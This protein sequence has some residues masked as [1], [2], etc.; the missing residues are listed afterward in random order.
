MRCEL[1]PTDIDLD[2]EWRPWTAEEKV[3]FVAP[4]LEDVAESIAVARADALAAYPDPLAPIDDRP[5]FEPGRTPSSYARQVFVHRYNPTTQRFHTPGGSASDPYAFEWDDA[6]R[7][8]LDWWISSEPGHSV[9]ADPGSPPWGKVANLIERMHPGDLV[10]MDRTGTKARRHPQNPGLSVPPRS[11][12]GVTAVEALTRW[13]DM[14]WGNWLGDVHMTPL[15]LFDVPVHLDSVRKRQPAMAAIGNFRG[16]SPFFELSERDDVLAIVQACGLPYTVLT[17]PDLDALARLLQTRPSGDLGAPWKELRPGRWRALQNTE[18]EWH[19]M[20]A[21]TWWL[22]QHGF[23]HVYVHRERGRGYDIAARRWVGQHRTDWHVEVK[24]SER[25]WPAP[26]SLTPNQRAV[27]ARDPLWRLA[28]VH[29]AK[30]GGSCELR[31][32]TNA[33]VAS[34]AAPLV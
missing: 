10:F 28:T 19:A 6:A 3:D 4:V 11:L 9:D 8:V 25:S 16:P 12:I 7:A 33:Q 2:A 20:A 31:W 22:F 24:G 30:Q 21:V 5:G 23:G 15:R 18:T 13:P 32:W 17:E 1:E 26:V 34:G 27:G 29:D 14:Q